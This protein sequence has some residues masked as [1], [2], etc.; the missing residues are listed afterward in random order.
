MSGEE[1]ID[2]Y[3]ML[4]ISPSA[5]KKEIKSAYRRLAMQWHPDKNKGSEE[6]AGDMFKRISE[7]YD[8]LSDENKRDL[9]D[10]YGIDGLRHGGPNH[11]EP[12]FR[13]QAD[14]FREVFGDSMFSNFFHTGSQQSQSSP[15]F[16]DFNH[17]AF[18]RQQY[19]QPQQQQ[20]SSFNDPFASHFGSFFGQGFGNS[21]FPNSFNQFSSPFGQSSSSIFSS[22]SSSFGNG[23]G[24]SMSQSSSTVIQNGTRITTTRTT[25]DGVTTERVETSDA[26]TGEVLSLVVD[27][28]DQPVGMLT[29]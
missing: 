6:E 20:Q 14:L 18:H 22:S 12:V 2:Y 15:F 4:G 17:S 3:D 16:D 25:R 23:I 19:Q 10:T 11:Q 9:Y 1:H 5:T 24:N 29:E 27:G 8:V 13:S 7:A 28:R 26:Q 21:M